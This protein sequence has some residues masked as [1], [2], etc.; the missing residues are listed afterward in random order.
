MINIRTRDDVERD[1]SRLLIS[2]SDLDL[3]MPKTVM[4]FWKLAWF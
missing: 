4:V 1:P 3:W 2:T